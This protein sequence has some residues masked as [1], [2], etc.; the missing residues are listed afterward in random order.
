[1]KLLSKEQAL[2]IIRKA[3]GKEG[4]H[5]FAANNDLSQAIISTSLTGA[6]GVS[7]KLLKAV[8]LRKAE[9]Y[10]RTDDA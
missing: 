5:K 6:R 7:P 10:E 3:V 1:M 9:A 8:G 4:Q 2:R